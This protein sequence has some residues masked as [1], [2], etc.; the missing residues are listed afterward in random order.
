MEMHFT[1]WFG[2]WIFM[3]IFCISDLWLFKQGYDTLFHAHKTKE[4]KLLQQYRICILK[5]EAEIKQ[6]ILESKRNNN[7]KPE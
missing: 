5:N 6:L 7:S 2:F 3:S 1:S 4:E